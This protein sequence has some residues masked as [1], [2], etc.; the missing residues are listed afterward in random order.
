[1]SVKEAGDRARRLNGME[2][3]WDEMVGRI[4]WVGSSTLSTDGYGSQEWR[5]RRLGPA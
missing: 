3:E 4:C 1:M 5:R 2:W